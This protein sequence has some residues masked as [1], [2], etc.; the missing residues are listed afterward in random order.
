MAKKR[1]LE[2]TIDDDGK[3]TIKVIGGEGKECLELTKEIE[4]A[5]GLVTE[6]T[7]TSEFYVEPAKTEE[8]VEKK[9]Q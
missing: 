8:K 5:L 1:E 6:R 2:F 3:I 4:E 7:K 9:G